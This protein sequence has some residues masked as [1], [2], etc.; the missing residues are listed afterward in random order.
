ME[1]LCQFDLRVMYI[2]GQDTPSYKVI[3]E[4]IN[5]YI[6]P[7]QYEIFI[8]ITQTII[9]MFDLN[10]DDQYL[11]GT[12]IKA[13]SNKYKF[14]WKPTTF[15]RRLDKKIKE[16]PSDMGYVSSNELISS[17]DVYQKMINYAVKEKIKINQIPNGK[18][19]RLTV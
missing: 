12:K 1:E 14:V 2:M 8:A 7:H 5:K 11:D 3:C 19:K 13:N 18:G 6:V 16:L 4:F 9:E 15:H 17:Y 10:M